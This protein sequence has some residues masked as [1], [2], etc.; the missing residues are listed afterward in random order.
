M[1]LFPETDLPKNVLW[2]RRLSGSIT[3]LLSITFF[4]FIKERYTAHSPRILKYNSTL[5]C[6]HIPRGIQDADVWKTSL[7][8]ATVNTRL[9][10]ICH[11][12]TISVGVQARRSGLYGDSLYSDILWIR[13]QEGWSLLFDDWTSSIHW[14]LSTNAH[15]SSGRVQRQPSGNTVHVK[16]WRQWNLSLTRPQSEGKNPCFSLSLS[17]C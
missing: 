9:C 4:H 6:E 10:D 17:Y 5:G 3:F 8:Q 2:Q 1:V 14:L 16:C 12:Y 11:I 7:N 15:H 13:Q